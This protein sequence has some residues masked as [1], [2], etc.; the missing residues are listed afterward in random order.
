MSSDIL[1]G[2]LSNIS[3]EILCGQG[4][5]GNTLILSFLFGSSGEHCDLEPAVEVRRGGGEEGVELT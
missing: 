3:S 2:T 5:A 4:P 1:S